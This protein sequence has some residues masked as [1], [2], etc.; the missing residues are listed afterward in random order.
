[1]SAFI[2]FISRLVAEIL[3]SLLK[4]RGKAVDGDSDPSVLRRSGSR[5]RNW[6]QSN[7]A[8]AGIKPDEGGSVGLDARVH[9][10]EG[11]VDPVRQQGDG[12]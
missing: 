12:S 2:A 5:I 4:D 9:D 3:A 1:M 11:R 10:A 7:R 6:V 8:G